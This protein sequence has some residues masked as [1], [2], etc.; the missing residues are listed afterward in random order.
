VWLIC[1]ASFH[2]FGRAVGHPASRSD[3]PPSSNSSSSSLDLSDDGRQLPNDTS[4]L[5]Q[6]RERHKL[7]ESTH[8]VRLKDVMPILEEAT[9]DLRS[10]CSTGL[11]A[12]KT[13]LD[14]INTRRYS[15]TGAI[16]SNQQVADLDNALERLRVSLEEFKNS[17]R[18]QLL[19]PFNPVIQE[20]KQKNGYIIPFR[21]LYIC[22]IFAS[23]LI[24]LA[25]GIVKLMEY[26]QLKAH[27]RGKNRLWAP[28]GLRAIG[29]ALMSKGDEND[30]AAG[31]DQVPQAQE[32]VKR[33]EAP[34]SKQSG[35]ERAYY[36]K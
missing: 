35:L 4:L 15:R 20:S 25:D 8:S 10:A 13:V 24:V 21:S 31:E 2:T 27:K 17:R 16:E 1:L 5:R 6:L 29:R 30:Q 22:F 28:G 32:E 19:Q 23:N 34:F 18:L 36:A 11:G 33:E 12:T 14:G 7:A 3:S 26:V 9:T